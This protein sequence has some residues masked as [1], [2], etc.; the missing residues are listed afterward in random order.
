[1]ETPMTR[2]HRRVVF[3]TPLLVA[4]LLLAGCAG[5]PSTSRSTVAAADFERDDSTTDVAGEATSAASDGGAMAGV[6]ETAP[7]RTAPTTRFE[8]EE[9]IALEAT[10]TLAEPSG[11]ITTIIGDPSLTTE[12]VRA[13]DSADVVD[14]LIGQINGRP[15]YAS[16]FFVPIDDRLEAFA[17]RVDAGEKTRG[18]FDQMAVQTIN[19][20]LRDLLQNEVF[21]AEA[22]TSFSA[23][24]R[25]EQIEGFKEY[26]RARLISERG[27]GSV[28]AAELWARLE[29]G[30]S[31]D[32][33]VQEY[34]ENELIRFEYAQEVFQD[35]TVTWREIER[36]Y[37]R[38]FDEFNPPASIRVRLL[39]V[40]NSE[41]RRSVIES[42]VEDGRTIGEL[43]DSGEVRPLHL[44]SDNGLIEAPLPDDLSTFAPFDEEA[45]L[46]VF[47]E[48]LPTLEAGETVGPIVFLDDRAVGWISIEDIVRPQP[49]S[50]YE[51]QHRL[52]GEIRQA[53]AQREQM[54]YLRD[55]L[56]R[57]SY[58][59]ERDM[60]RLL[61]NIAR[62]RYL[63]DT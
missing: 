48:T 40:A 27:R 59:D 60:S 24:S 11:R 15:V 29:H 1:M 23:E 18:E 25:V 13:R 5:G 21:L 44:R 6:D 46:A 61:L 9:P 49:V 2:S 47:N 10:T 30:K 50:L 36:E 26:T 22:E 28:E 42:A 12:A 35:V 39:T 56:P 55:I 34:V 17:R 43:I 62:Q 57:T 4:L 16:A 32:S 33:Y 14:A 41:V 63:G 53:K 37:Y 51:A 3:S 45:G 58:T 8:D 38:R 19:R 20:R 31:L 7:V 54:K 52:R